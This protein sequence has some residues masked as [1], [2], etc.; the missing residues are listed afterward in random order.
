MVKNFSPAG[1]RST[2]SAGAI[3]ADLRVYELDLDQPTAD[4]TQGPAM[5]EAARA[6]AMAYGMMAAEPGIDLL[7]LGEMGI[8]NTTGRGDAVRGAVRRHGRGLGR[9]RH[10]RRTAR[11]SATR[12]R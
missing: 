3:D 4:F 12:S 8:A 10:R 11:R 5:S 7:C 9:P 2:S 6:N 1:R